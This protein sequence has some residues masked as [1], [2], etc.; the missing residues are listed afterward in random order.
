MLLDTF[1][2]LEIFHVILLNHYMISLSEKP[3]EWPPTVWFSVKS[4]F[5]II[6]E[7]VPFAN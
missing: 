3:V 4:V 7:R 6:R 5:F 2:D 1:L